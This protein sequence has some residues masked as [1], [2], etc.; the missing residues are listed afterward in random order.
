MVELA[1]DTFKEKPF[2]VVRHWLILDVMLPETTEQEIKAQGLEA[3]V[4][5]AQ[6]AVFDSQ[7]KHAP[8]DSILSGYL[9]DFDGC[10]FESKDRLYILAGRGA[11]KYVSLPALQAL[12]AYENAGSGA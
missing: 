4:L 11:R 8:G 6:S 7:N 10:I 2:C 3:T 9:R 1:A 12:N 5:Y